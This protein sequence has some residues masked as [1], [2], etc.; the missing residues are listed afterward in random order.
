MTGNN[1]ILRIIKDGVTHDLQI[2]KN[3]PLR[4]DMS[5]LESQQI[6]KLFSVGSQ[7]FF[8]PGTSDSNKFFDFAFNPGTDTAVGMYNTLPVSVIL[9]GDVVLEGQLQLVEAISSDDGFKSYKVR[10]IDTPITLEGELRGKLIKNADWSSYNHVLTS[11]SVVDSWTD[12][13]LSGS[14]YYPL[15]H[16]GFPDGDSGSYAAIYMGNSQSNDATISNPLTP[17][18][19]AQ[20][21]PAVKVKDTLDVIF[22]QAGFRYTGSFTETADFN[23]VYILNKPQEGLGPVISG[24]NPATFTA[25]TGFGTNVQSYTIDSSEP[26]VGDRVMYIDEQSDPSNLYTPICI[27]TSTGYTGSKYD[28]STV[29][30]TTFTANLSAFNPTFSTLATATIKL[31]LCQGST[32]CNGSGESVNV[33]ASDEIS[34]N[35]AY[36]LNTFNLQINHTFTPTA[37]GEVFL[38]LKYFRTAGSGGSNLD[39]G[40][41][42][43]TFQ[44]TSAPDNVEGATID[45]SLQWNPDTKSTDVLNGIIQQ[46]NLVLLPSTTERSTIEIAQFD[47]WIRAGELKDWTDKYDTSKRISV[48]HTIEDLEDEIL[49]QNAE[50]EDRFSKQTIDNDPNFQYGTTRL[51]ADNNISQGQKT[52][53]DYFAPVILGG[54]TGVIPYNTEFPSTR[55]DTNTNFIYPHLYKFED[56]QFK[57]FAFKP[58]IGYKVNNNLLTGQAFYLGFPFDELE[59]TG[60]YGTISNVSDLPV[61]ASVS[62]D[63]H[64]NNTY[65]TFTNYPLYLLNSGVS[66][67]ANYYQTYLDSLY[68]TGSK[69]LT[70]DLYFTPTDYKGIKLNDKISIQGQLYRINKIKGFNLTSRDV[71]TVELIKLYPQYT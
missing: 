4:V 54:A 71:V 48:S 58:R 42:N 10:V 64:F 59:V 50:D 27:N 12:G 66:N 63:L 49:L 47:D 21:L 22:D 13:I 56:S 68:W 2:D 65:T 11:Q 14:V 55:I 61:T 69:K 57:S 26:V 67:Y 53:G 9:N 43:N 29:G 15:A 1:I 20:F 51:L 8:I 40:Y 31:E 3:V 18:Q 35:S 5:T 52:I 34:V 45:M 60:S 37:G 33:V 46:F 70:L 44:C 17:M 32:P 36:G 38:L 39:V 7:E 62:N 6:G 24:S 16:Y 19:T 41:F 25:F 30:E 28:V 23:K